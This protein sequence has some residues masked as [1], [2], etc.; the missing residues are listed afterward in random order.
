MR[1]H[2]K[3]PEILE[4][5]L[6]KLCRH[7]LHEEILGDLEEYFQELAEVPSWKRYIFYWF[8]ALNF[9]RPFALKIIGQQ[10]KFNQFNLIGNY[11]K[12]S[13]RSMM[14]SPLSSFINVVGLAI[15]IGVCIW[16]YAFVAN[17]YALDKHHVN[18][19]EIYLIT[20]EMEREGTVNRY[21]NSPA[22]MAHAMSQ[23]LSGIKNFCRIED[24]NAIV[25][26]EEQ[27]FHE[28]IRF[29]DASFLE[30]FTFPL[31]SGNK[32]SLRDPNHIILNDRMAEK[33]FR[34]EDP[35]GKQLLLK[36][37]A[38]RSKLFTVTGIAEP[39]PESRQIEF[40]FLVNFD[41]LEAHF[42]DFHHSDWSIFVDATFIQVPNSEDIAQISQASSQYKALQNRVQKDWSVEHFIFEQIDGLHLRARGF[43][44]SLIRDR[45]YEGRVSLPVVAILMLVL[46]CLNY[47]NIAIVSASRRLKEIGMRKVI[48]ASKGKIVFQ[49]LAENILV[50][51][52]ALVLG[53]VF[54]R[55][56]VL[57][58][59]RSLSELELGIHIF[60]WDLWAF[61]LLVVVVTGII[62]GIYPAFYISRFEVIKI[63]R[64][65]LRFGKKNPV[66]KLFLGFQLVLACIGTTAAVMF[67]QN[68]DYQ[69]SRSWGYEQHGVLYAPVADQSGYTLLAAAL[70]QEP[71][72]E[73]ISGGEHHLGKSEDKV[74]LHLPS[75]EFEAMRLAV[76]D[77]Y[78]PM[79]EMEFVD[80]Q[81]FRKD[82]ASG[83]TA[84]VINEYLAESLEWTDPVG[85][86]FRIDSVRYEVIG[87]V[88]DFHLKNFYYEMMPIL[89]TLAEDA[90]IRYLSFKAQ[91]GQEVET[92]VA[93]RKHWTALFPESPF[94]GGHQEDVW[95]NFYLEMD[96]M[97]EYNKVIAGV[98]LI[99]ASLGL[100]GLITLNVVGRSKEFSIRK[101]LGARLRHLAT[102]IGRQYLILGA[103]S[104]LIGAPASY[105][106]IKANIDMMFPDPRPMEIHGV[107]V[108]VFIIFLVLVSVI[109]TQIGKV[110]NTNPARGLR[111]E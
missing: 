27:V 62:S 35:L 16:V 105:F 12:T 110:L 11:Y 108:S 31:R 20:Y 23:D 54:C 89:F 18:G 44:K 72:I 76:A 7:E 4:K 86:S 42:D 21:G 51:M 24:R 71:N 102:S 58:W 10:M 47:I 109:C 33:Y 46:A 60:H 9:L 70:G 15:A 25:K 83:K 41:N 45:Y 65:S 52:F 74:V 55:V 78:L 43:R 96:M 3:P 48:G 92:Y 1:D 111:T 106:L 87:V 63:F 100:Y 95:G 79:M 26:F 82:H 69:R 36:F 68:S 88:K 103:I 19:H 107:F 22:P 104:L 85:K 8:Q 64:G 39:F 29:A 13:I 56:A 94:M 80:G 98:A 32:L 28:R 77:D 101:A 84:V 30:M 91:A 99:L 53:L 34:D 90:N 67:T 14:R 17:D 40:D 49:F 97:E 38:E 2:P 59:F 93:L 50:T 61:L 37:D 75:R 6:L 57:P 5:A 66:T 73:L 81:N